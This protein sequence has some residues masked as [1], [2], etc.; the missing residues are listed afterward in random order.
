MTNRFDISV[1]ATDKF[2]VVFKTLNKA[3]TQAVAPLQA[4]PKTVTPAAQEAGKATARVFDAKPLR[5]WN[6]NLMVGLN[7]FERFATS[8]GGLSPM[9]QAMFGVAGAGG[10][11]A[12]GAAIVAF[13]TKYAD[14]GTQVLRTSQRTGLATDELQKWAAAAKAAGYNAETMTAELEKFA[15]TMQAAKYGHN[16]NAFAAMQ[17][18]GGGVQM[19]NG[20]V[21][22]LANLAVVVKKLQEIPTA[23]ARLT[24]LEQLGMNPEMLTFYL[25]G[26]Q[27]IDALKDEAARKG[28]VQSAAA[29]D[30]AEKQ[31]QAVNALGLAWDRVGLSIG[32]LAS[33]RLSGWLNS[34]ADQI[35]RIPDPSSASMGGMGRPALGRFGR[36][37][38]HGA[39]GSWGS[40]EHGATAPRGSPEHGATAPRGSPEHGATGSWGDDLDTRT[41]EGKAR[42]LE[43][44][45]N[46]AQF[47]SEDVRKRVMA[48]VDA[49]IGVDIRVHIAN[50][51]PGTTVSA[52][53]TGNAR[54]S[55]SMPTATTP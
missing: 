45:V 34:L 51:P 12:A 6:A 39:T 3:A 41:G 7:T 20:A 24:F 32:A 54:I 8:V 15:R 35:S 9:S 38:E 31:R 23:Q 13:T 11:L 46:G 29:L 27:K 37:V 52:R 4:I 28:S 2:S 49:P 40:P 26:L 19:K 14:M 21:D 17:W 30:Q 50:A 44:V 22:T 36:N 16:Q 48:A 25:L 10:F 5:A 47:S 55:H 43:D 42:I 53:S 33:P 1:T 18:A